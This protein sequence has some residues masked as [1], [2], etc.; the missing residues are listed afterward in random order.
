[1]KSASKAA[2][3]YR[4]AGHEHR[5]RTT[6][7]Q[8]YDEGLTRTIPKDALRTSMPGYTKIMDERYTMG[9]LLNLAPG[10]DDEYVTINGV[11]VGRNGPIF[12]PAFRVD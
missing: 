1:M 6:P 9:W 7:Y 3:T 10:S 12:F 5:T 4:Q 8:F 2:L 11:S